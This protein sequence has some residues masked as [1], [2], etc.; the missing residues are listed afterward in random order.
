M[1]NYFEMSKDQLRAEKAA[2]EQSYAEFKAKGLKL[3]MARGNPGPHQM[4]LAMDLAGITGS[5]RPPVARKTI[6][7]MA[8]DHGVAE[9]GVSKYPQEVTAQMV[10]GLTRSSSRVASHPRSTDC[11]GSSSWPIHC[12]PSSPLA[13]RPWAPARV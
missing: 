3:N 8:G 11:C 9:E 5:M 10:Q 13:C 7:T 6:V 4:D 2:L 1:A 12:A